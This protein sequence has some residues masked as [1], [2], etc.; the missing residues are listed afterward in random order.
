M[1]KAL[2]SKPI[3]IKVGI[4]GEPLHLMSADQAI[5]VLSNRWRTEGSLKQKAAIRACRLAVSGEFSADMARH[6][7]IQAAREANVLVE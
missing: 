1:Y 5:A 2:F 4:V 6:E 3:T 7:V